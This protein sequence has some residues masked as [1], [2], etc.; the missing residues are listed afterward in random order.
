VSPRH[1]RPWAVHLVGNAIGVQ[2]G[3]PVLDESF[4]ST[5]AGLYIA[6]F[7]ATQDFGPFF[8]FVRGAIP[9]ASM[10]VED[11]LARA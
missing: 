8:G 6:G 10:V 4:A 3:Y 11:L 2:N 1:Q 7:P 9:T 5:T